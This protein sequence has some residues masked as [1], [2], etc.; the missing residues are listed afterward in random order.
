MAL[1]GA[2]MLALIGVGCFFFAWTFWF[3]APSPAHILYEGRPV[4]DLSGLRG[5]LTV[6]FSYFGM[7]WTGAALFVVS[8]ALDFDVWLIRRRLRKDRWSEDADNG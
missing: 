3:E 4:A 6:V 2:L 1:L 8:M 7:M 5:P